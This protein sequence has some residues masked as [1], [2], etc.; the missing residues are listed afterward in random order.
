[1]SCF[2]APSRFI[3]CRAQNNAPAQRRDGP[4]R[5]DIANR[6]HAASSDEHRCIRA[7]RQQNLAP[8]T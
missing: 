4:R 7:E 8:T 3:W 1:V 6:R 5:S 2:R